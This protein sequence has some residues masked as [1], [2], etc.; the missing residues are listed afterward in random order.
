MTHD[1]RQIIIWA[2]DQ[3]DMVIMTSAKKNPTS[4]CN[5]M[6]ALLGLL[7]ASHDCMGQV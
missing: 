7:A 5:G 4:Q 3:L 2:R 6:L 1:E